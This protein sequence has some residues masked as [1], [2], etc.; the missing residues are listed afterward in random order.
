MA[1]RLSTQ[2]FQKISTQALIDISSN[3]VATAWLNAVGLVQKSLNS[4]G[5]E[6]EHVVHGVQTRCTPGNEARRPHGPARK[7]VAS[8]RGA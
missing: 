8:G 5:L 6:S 4:C 1:A 7:G 2:L 3:S